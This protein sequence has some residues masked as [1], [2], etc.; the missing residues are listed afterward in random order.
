MAVSSSFK[1]GSGEGYDQIMGRWSARLAEVFLDFCGCSDGEDIL[2]AGC[3]T[4][5]LTSALARRIKPRSITGVDFSPIY[6]D[7]ASGAIRDPRITFEVGDICALPFADRSFDRVLSL[8]VLHFV[9][10]T[11]RA[12][13]ELRRVA[14]PGATVAAAVWDVR[15]GYVA[16]RMFYDTAAA[17]DDEGRKRRAHNYTRPMTRPGELAAVWRA[18]GFTDVRETALHIRMEFGAFDDF[19][20][21]LAGKDGPGAEYLAALPVERRDR[22]R[23]LVR[24]AYL[25]GEPDGP[26][27]YAAIA[28]AVTGIVPG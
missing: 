27:S 11:A 3:G 17:F 22:L 20:T 18:A 2:D 7:H 9:P 8:L 16:N 26:R 15:G 25:D 10:Q 14:R 28:W 5:S 12:V 4:G 13:A 23:D 6:V 1:A 21:P 19:W 24:D